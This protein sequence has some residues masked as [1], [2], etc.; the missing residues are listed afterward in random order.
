MEDP[1]FDGI[2][3]DC[4]LF[5]AWS[6][7][8]IAAD[9]AHPSP[10]YLIP[11]VPKSAVAKLAEAGL[12]DILQGHRYRIHGLDAERERRRVAATSRGPSGDRT[13]TKREANGEQDEAETRRDET[14]RDEADDDRADLEAF[15]LVTRRAPTSRQRKLLDELLVRHDV[16]GPQW[17]ADI[18]LRHPDDPIGAVIEADKAWR[19]E[20]I[21]EAKRSERPKP[22]PHRRPG[23][24]T[25][26][27]E[28]LEHWAAKETA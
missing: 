4:R 25:S 14:R 13:G 10:A 11:T 16:N 12:I 21:E 9:M 24:P 2:R 27:R 15:V 1:K 6:L 3:E 5:G 20:R 19:T 18:M 23:L 22:R 7:L 28:L 8:L 26:T 17:A